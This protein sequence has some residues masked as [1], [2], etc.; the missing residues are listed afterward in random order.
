ME[1][2]IVILLLVILARMPARP[3]T[4]KPAPH[5]LLKHIPFFVGLI[6]I[7]GMIVSALVGYA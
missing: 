7:L 2:I 5:P 4:P 6:V 1:L 3:P